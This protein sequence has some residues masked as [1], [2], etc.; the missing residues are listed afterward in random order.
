MDRSDSALL[1]GL[2]VRDEKSIRT[3]VSTYHASMTR[4]ARTIVGNDRA[5]EIVQE[6]WIKAIRALPT[7]EARSSLRTWLLSIVRNE[8]ISQLCKENREPEV[9]SSDELAERFGPDGQWT[10]PPNPWSTDNPETLLATKDL[11]AVIS[12]ALESMPEAQRS[13]L[14]LNDMEGLSSDEICNILGISASDARVLLHRGR[15]RLWSAS[16]RIRRVD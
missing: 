2:A 8:A 4:F 9:A 14:T 10:A 11:Q 7:F 12:K 13:V 6:A 16:K 5:E 15:H 1:P 3:L